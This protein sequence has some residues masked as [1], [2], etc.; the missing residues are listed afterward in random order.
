MVPYECKSGPHATGDIFLE[1]Y[2][3][4]GIVYMFLFQ[5]S[6]FSVTK[7]TSLF[8]FSKIQI[9]WN[10]FLKTTKLNMFSLFLFWKK[11]NKQSQK[12]IPN[13]LLVSDLSGSAGQGCSCAGLPC[14][15]RGLGLNIRQ[16]NKWVGLDLVLASSAQSNIF[17]PWLS[18]G[19]APKNMK[20]KYGN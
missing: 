12:I 3:P 4:F 8:I 14:F 1:T 7:E 6:I 2:G 15:R 19:F 13:S 20:K 10:I 16:I 11:A 17:Y 18:D 9:C 5:K